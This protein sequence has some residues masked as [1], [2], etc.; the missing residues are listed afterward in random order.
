MILINESLCGNSQS[1]FIIREATQI[2]GSVFQPVF[3]GAMGAFN[4]S[5]EVTV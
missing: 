2:R 5:A 1:A 3:G 4:C